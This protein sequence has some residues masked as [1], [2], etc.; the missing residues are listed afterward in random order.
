LA[1]RWGRGDRS[2]ADHA[3]WQ[4]SSSYRQGVTGFHRAERDEKSAISTY[5]LDIIFS[6]L[7]LFGHI[8][9]ILNDCSFQSA[10]VFL[11]EI[12]VIS[13]SIEKLSYLMF[14]LSRRKYWSNIEISTRTTS[15]DLNNLNDH[16]FDL[17]FLWLD[18]EMLM[19]TWD[20]L[21]IYWLI[22]NCLGF[23]RFACIDNKVN[24]S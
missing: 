15:N 7:F 18:P 17:H 24:E 13:A 4:Y 11:L 8:K 6:D 20:I 19:G 5:S 3:C 1:C 14:S 10:K 2:K 23:K 9:E 16:V 22:R 12:Q 21:C